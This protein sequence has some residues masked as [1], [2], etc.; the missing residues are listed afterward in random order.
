MWLTLYNYGLHF[1]FFDAILLNRN[2][3]L[4]LRVKNN[5]AEI[6]ALLGTEELRLIIYFRIQKPLALQISL[7]T[8]YISLTHTQCA[9]HVWVND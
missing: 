9:H 3:E 2:N 7:F 4:S 5:L 1:V 6:F 8:K